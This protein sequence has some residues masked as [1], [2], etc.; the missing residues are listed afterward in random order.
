M[1]STS[2]GNTAIAPDAGVPDAAAKSRV[3][4][5]MNKDHKEDLS[6]YLRHFKSL[7]PAEASNPEM[8]DVDLDSVTIRS[9]SG[10][11]TFAIHP[12]MKSW[13]DRRET[14]ANMTYLARDA[15]EPVA[16]GM[17]TR[18][19]G[20]DLLVASMV[21]FYF[22]C[23]G[24]VQGGYVE[25][26]SDAWRGLDEAK[27]PWGAWGFV[28]LVNLIFIPVLVIHVTEVWYFDR[29][30]LS[31]H[32]IRRGSRLWWQWTASNFLEGYCAFI[33]FDGLVKSEERRRR[34]GEKSG[35]SH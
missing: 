12:P 33:R 25:P 9:A 17:W 20:Q 27:F 29:T 22:L 15:L 34:E 18:P 21:S 14:L 13:N 6:L 24:L 11:H 19:R 1:A 10:T 28:T 7:T 30:R 32:G 3:I 26:G 35:K 31:R 8:T 5:H 16:I 4:A 2:Q 23:F